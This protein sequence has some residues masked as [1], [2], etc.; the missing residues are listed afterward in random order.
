VAVD[1]VTGTELSFEVGAPDLIRGLGIKHR[2]DWNDSPQPSTR[3]YQSI[4][5]EDVVGSRDGRPKDIRLLI[6]KNRKDLLGAPPGVIP[7]EIE[8]SLLLKGWGPV[9][10]AVGSPRT[11]SQPFPA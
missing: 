3:S 9:G 1:A 11:I 7:T 10:M 4:S 6:S 2:R 8:E 5:F